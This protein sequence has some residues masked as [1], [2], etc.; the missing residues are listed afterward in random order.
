MTDTVHEEK[1]VLNQEQKNALTLLERERTEEKLWNCVVLF[2]NETFKTMSG[3]FFTYELKLGRDGKYTKE[4]WVNR[5][6]NSKSLTWSS[7]WR[8]FERTEGKTVV[9]R[10]KDLGDIRG[11]SYI[12]GIFYRFGLIEV[13][14]QVRVKMAE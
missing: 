11:I 6:E 7:V 8:A 10:P 5:R 9:A 4:L 3:L 12:Y 13:P 1:N 14:E 2:Q